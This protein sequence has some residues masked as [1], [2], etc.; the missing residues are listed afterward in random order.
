MDRVKV[1]LLSTSPVNGVRIETLVYILVL[2]SASSCVTLTIWM[3]SH[4]IHK[5]P[6]WSSSSPP[7]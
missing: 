4:H 3:S 6:P 2:N 7:A 1:N 5:S